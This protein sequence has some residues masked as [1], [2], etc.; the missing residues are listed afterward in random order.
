MARTIEIYGVYAQVSLAKSEGP[1]SQASS[2][3]LRAESNSD[4]S[5]SSLYRNTCI[6]PYPFVIINAQPMGRGLF[7]LPPRLRPL[8]PTTH[9]LLAEGRW[10]VEA[11]HRFFWRGDD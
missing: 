9:T 8:G 1:G 11:V 7:S 4:Y 6:F 3:P 5:H 2:V 10:Q